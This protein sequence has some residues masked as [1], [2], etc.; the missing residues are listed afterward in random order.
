M[1][2]LFPIDSNGHCVIPYGTETIE[3]FTYNDKLISIEIPNSVT[4]IGEYAFIICSGLTS[5][6]IPDSVTQIGDYAF[7]G[8]SGLTSITVSSELAQ[9]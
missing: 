3:D 6:E 7:S 8:C 4:Q 5:I 2:N 1:S 9:D